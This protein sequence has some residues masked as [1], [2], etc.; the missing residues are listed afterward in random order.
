MAQLVR[1]IVL[2]IPTLIT[3]KV[4]EVYYHTLISEIQ[5]ATESLS[6]TQVLKN[7][8]TLFSLSNY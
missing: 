7:D 1:E 3:E 8:Y 5:V 2:H 6:I 4:L